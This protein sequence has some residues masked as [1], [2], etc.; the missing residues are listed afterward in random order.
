MEKILS[1]QFFH[2]RCCFS[3]KGKSMRSPP[4]CTI[5][6][7]S[8]LPLTLSPESG[9]RWIPLGTKRAILAEAAFR[10]VSTNTRQESSLRLR[11]ELGQPRIIVL[12]FIPPKP[13]VW[14]LWKEVDGDRELFSGK[15]FSFYIVT[16]DT[17]SEI[18]EALYEIETFPS[19]ISE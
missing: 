13:A 10:I 2:V 12:G 1:L 7:M 4:S 14:I 8:M 5:H 9:N 19:P 3:K 18:H 11:Q 17:I 15:F 6:Q 16:D